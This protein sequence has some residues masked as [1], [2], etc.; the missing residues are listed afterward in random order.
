MQ[1][2]LANVLEFKERQAEVEEALMRLKE[3]NQVGGSNTVPGV[4]L[5]QSSSRSRAGMELTR[6]RAPGSHSCSWRS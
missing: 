5:M 6:F 1:A 4:V 3:E 2:D